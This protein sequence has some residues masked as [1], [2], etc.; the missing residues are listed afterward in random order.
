MV[1]KDASTDGKKGGRTEGVNLEENA[2][3]KKRKATRYPPRRKH[4]IHN[5]RNSN[6]T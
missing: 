2:E 5:Q 3:G 6:E 1:E 4:E